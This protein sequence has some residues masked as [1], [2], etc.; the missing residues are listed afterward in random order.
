MVADFLVEQGPCRAV[1]TGPIEYEPGQHD[2]AAEMIGVGPCAG[3]GASN[4]AVWESAWTTYDDVVKHTTL[5]VCGGCQEAA[6][7]LVMNTPDLIGIMLAY[8]MR[9]GDFSDAQIIAAQP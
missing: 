7:Q 2:G 8:R 9:R 4:E 3:C 1:I 5:T 6:L